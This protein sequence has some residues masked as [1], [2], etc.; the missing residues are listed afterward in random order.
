MKRPT[1]LVATAALFAGLLTTMASPPSFAAGSCPFPVAGGSSTTIAAVPDVWATTNGEVSAGVMMYLPEQVLVVG[2]N[3]TAVVQK[4]GTTAPA[5]N[6]AAIRVS[7]GKVVWNGNANSTVYAL[8]AINGA[9]FAAGAFTGIG[10]TTKRGLA[11]LNAFTGA[12]NTSFTAADIGTVRAVV[13]DAA[14]IVYYGGG[15]KLRAVNAGSGGGIWEMPVTKGGVRALAVNQYNMLYVGG[16]F[17]TINY[18]QQHGLALIYPASYGQLSWGFTPHL[19][20]NSY[21]GSTHGTYDG[22]NTISL[23]W[24]AASGSLL[25][26]QAG[27]INT[28]SMREAWS[29]QPSWWAYTDGDV[30][31][32]S[33]VGSLSL[34]GWHRN[35]GNVYGCPYPIF[36]GSFDLSGGQI[37]TNWSPGLTGA[38]PDPAALNGG[39]QSF[40]TTADKVYILGGFNRWGASCN[41]YADAGVKPGYS[42]VAGSGWDRS[43]IAVYSHT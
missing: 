39:V 34:G 24:S 15:N 25:S 40:V 36:G 23:R 21:D 19:I 13:A 4:D 17:D 7:D 10:G 1:I 2:G 20:R 43:G 32:V 42:C 8:D 14:G 12:V 31:G 38:L 26:G 16:L 28:I 18:W 3:F 27:L 9:V 33:T 22:E 11:S 6:L 30:Q 41:W 29:G 5:K 35:Q 37:L